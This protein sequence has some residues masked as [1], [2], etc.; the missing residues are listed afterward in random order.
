MLM[1]VTL[2]ANAKILAV[3]AGTL[4]KL[5]AWLIG[6]PALFVPDT[7]ALVLLKLMFCKLT[8]LGQSTSLRNL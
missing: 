7:S 2:V 4:F 8:F 6:L 1:L 3:K 5:C